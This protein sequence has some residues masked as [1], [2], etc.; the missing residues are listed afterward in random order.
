MGRDHSASG[1]LY[2]YNQIMMDAYFT[3]WDDHPLL[4]AYNMQGQTSQIV[5]F[6]N[7]YE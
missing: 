6:L 7:S 5:L 4:P 3:N 1:C 2:P